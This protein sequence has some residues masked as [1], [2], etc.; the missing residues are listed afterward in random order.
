M[1]SLFSPRSFAGALALGA[2]C[3]LASTLSACGSDEV[4]NR[5]F[6]KPPDAQTFNPGL[7]GGD[8]YGYGSAPEKPFACPDPLKR[9]SHTI[10]YPFNGE[11]S[12]ELRGDFGGPDTWVTGKPMTKKGNVWTVDL[13]VPYAKAVMFKFFVNGSMIHQC[14][15]GQDLSFKTNF[16]VSCKS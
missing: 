13:T 2:G 12:V 14:Y 8:G 11:T 5:D 9:C 7:G 3:F 10:T 15:G 16:E 1:I 4:N 6:G